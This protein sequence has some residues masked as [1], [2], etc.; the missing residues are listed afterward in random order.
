MPAT[1]ARGARGPR[2]N[3]ALDDEIVAAAAGL[4]AE[5]GYDAMS[6]DAVAARAGVSKATIYRRWPGKAP[7]VLD[8]VRSRHLPIGEPPDTGDLRDDLLALFHSLAAQLDEQAL[9]HL[10]GV[11]VAM[12]KHPEL[13][14]AVN[15][16]VVAGWARATRTILDRAVAR[17]EI[18][19]R[20]DDVVERFTTIGPS[21]V[22]L[23]LFLDEGPIDQALMTQ[24]V[25]EVLLPI[26]RGA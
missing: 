10:S 11:L 2:Y 19:T 14:H 9:D 8:T 22:A 18:A 1:T 15:E 16:Q 4:L 12:R 17:G 3:D 23:R 21:V 7:L 13:S 5:V 26:L 25:D 20:P 6:M 24:L